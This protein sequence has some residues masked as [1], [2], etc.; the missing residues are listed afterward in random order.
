VSFG[1]TEK[2]DVDK[3]EQ[4]FPSHR[5]FSFAA[6]DQLLFEQAARTIFGFNW[7]YRQTFTL[8]RILRFL[9]L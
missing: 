1:T 9:K 8:L 2:F 5:A 4:G 7:S 6:G 3:Q